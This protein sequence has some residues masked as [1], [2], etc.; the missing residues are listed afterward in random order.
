MPEPVELENGQ[1]VQYHRELDAY[2]KRQDQDLSARFTMLRCV[3]DNL[4]REY[5]KYS[6]A[7]ELCEVLKVTYG[8]TS[9]TRLR[10]LTL[11]SLREQ[12][13]GHVKL[14]LMHNEQIKMFNSIPSHLKLEAN[15][16]VS[17][18][19]QQA[20]LVAHASQY[21]SYKGKSL[22]KPTGARQS[23]ILACPTK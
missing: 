1:T 11:R 3:H 23:Q 10:V 20:A 12:T 9:A 21:K 18:R 15:H 22:S 17:E 13:W 14:V 19:A 8:S 7:K 2:I 6:T 4:I 5:E 16:R